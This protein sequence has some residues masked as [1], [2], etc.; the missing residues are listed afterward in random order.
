VDREEEAIEAAVLIGK[1]NQWGDWQF[2]EWLTG[3]LA[4][5]EWLALVQA[6]IEDYIGQ[7]LQTW[8]AAASAYSTALLEERGLLT[9]AA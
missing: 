6:E 8:S 2:N 7:I 4:D 9:L 1:T 5:P 3:R